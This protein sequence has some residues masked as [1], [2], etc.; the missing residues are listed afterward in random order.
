[1]IRKELSF[2]DDS[3]TGQICERCITNA[4]LVPLP[5]A[6]FALAILMDLN[7]TMCVSVHW[8]SWPG[9]SYLGGMIFRY[10]SWRKVSRNSKENVRH[11]GQLRKGFSLRA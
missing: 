5:L 1:M 6:F 7:E 4:Y 2:S 11:G 9:F 3:H 8:L 10:R